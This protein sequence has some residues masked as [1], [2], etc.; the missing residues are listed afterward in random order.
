MKDEKKSII[1]EALTDYQEIMD[2][3]DANA[4]KKLAEEFPEKFSNL[5]KEELNKN[6]KSA[7]ESY[8]KLDEGK[9]SEKDNT[10]SIKES[11]M[12]KEVKET[13]KVVKE[14]TGKGGDNF[15]VKPTTPDTLKEEREKEFM[16]DVEGQ[17][18]NQGKGTAEKGDAFL[19]KLKGPSS[20]TPMPNLKEEI[21]LTELDMS[22]VDTAMSGAG[23][24]DQVLTMEA[25]EE[26]IKAMEGLN[27][28]LG[29]PAESPS[30]DNKG[31]AFKQLVGIKNQID[32]ILNTMGQGQVEEQKRSGGQGA[33]K[34]NPGG[35]THAMIDEKQV[36]EMHQ[37]K[38]VNDPRGPDVYTSKLI[39]EKDEITD[40]DINAVLGA[41]SQEQPVEEALGMALSTSKGVAG[42]HLPGV[43]FG[44]ERHKR[45]GSVNNPRTNESEKKLGSLINENKQLTKKLNEVKKYKDSVGTLLE[46]YK[47]ALEKYRNQLKEMAIFNTNLAHVNNLLVNESLA[48]T[49]DDKIKIINEFKKVDSI[50]ESQKK[51]KT[52]LT[53]MKEGKK[54]LTESVEAKV[55]TSVAS[56]SKQKL[57]EVVEKTAYADDKHIQKMRKLIEYVENRGKK[58]IK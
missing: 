24:E 4:K 6:K 27:Q 56:S 3:A 5:L 33:N 1:K 9:E 41:K 39:D 40:A 7:K 26:E 57:D 16:G 20:G 10:E 48:L 36:D 11:V 38:V 37:G 52:F 44:S 47:T 23:P 35:P 54:T 15:T 22:G 12:K 50:A 43:E 28:E 58:I 46:N 14:D 13:K 32:E 55:T 29:A 51:Y 53:E 45:L 25:I 21:D 8:K 2:A 18:P 31:I 30:G 17:T 49:Q 42:D 34:V 19:D